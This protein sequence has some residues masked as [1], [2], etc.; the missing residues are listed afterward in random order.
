M[1]NISFSLTTRQFRDGSKDVT[2]RVNWQNL[3]PGDHLMAC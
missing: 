1:R 3:K 2:R